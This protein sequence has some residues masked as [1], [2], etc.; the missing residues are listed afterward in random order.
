MCHVLTLLTILGATSRAAVPPLV[1]LD[2]GHG[3][4]D[5]GARY[6]SYRGDF[7]EKDVA[8]A[9]ALETRR[10]LRKLGIRTLLTR[11]HDQTLE[12]GPR[13]QLA[14]E[15]GAAA[16][17]SIHLNSSHG[18]S[19]APN[20]GGIETFTLASSDQTPLKLARLGGSV[21]N[22][23]HAAKVAGQDPEADSDLS[24]VLKDMWLDSNVRQSQRLASLIQ[25]HLTHSTLRRNRGVKE[26][27]FHVL[28]GADMPSV[29]VEAGFMD[30][31]KDRAIL[32]SAEGRKKVARAL[33]R[34][35]KRFVTRR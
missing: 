20:A 24:L 21:L 17:V 13:T 16:F 14:N 2:P 25:S 35:V 31:A 26:A 30:S 1:V 32:L 10:E 27:H 34:A 18:N 15:E 28:L 12:L 6:K 7:Y 9:L 19:F 4:T 33:A 11:D 22:K 8:L 29:L 23:S 3:G 5:L